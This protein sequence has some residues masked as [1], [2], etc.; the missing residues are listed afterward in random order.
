MFYVLQ[1]ES[2]A[3]LRRV[4]ILLTDAATGT[5]AQTGIALTNI[6]PYVNINGG[7]FAG[8]AGTVAEAGYGQ[9]YYQFDASEVATLGL[10]GIHITA[11]GCRDY[12]A[13]AQV[14]AF[15]MYSGG[16]VGISAGDVWQYDIS[17]ITTAGTAGSQLNTASTGVGISAADVWNYSGFTDPG[18]VK[19]TLENANTKEPTFVVA[20]K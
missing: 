20:T 8:G 10:A 2:T 17:G 4:P 5:S 14:A 19:E 3:A 13:I 7:A 15:N 12:D 9:Y 6:F 18:T 16:G 11:S 1:N